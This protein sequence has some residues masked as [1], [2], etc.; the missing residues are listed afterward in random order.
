MNLSLDCGA[1]PELGGETEFELELEFEADRVYSGMTRSRCGL[2][3]TPTQRGRDVGSNSK[4]KERIENR[5]W[6]Q[7]CEDEFVLP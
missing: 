3:S 5:E 7:G 4:G 1:V 6:V 2:R